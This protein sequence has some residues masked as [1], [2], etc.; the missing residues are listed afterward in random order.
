MPIEYDIF[1]SF[2][3]SDKDWLLTISNSEFIKTNN[4]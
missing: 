4:G 3:N 1:I 2:K